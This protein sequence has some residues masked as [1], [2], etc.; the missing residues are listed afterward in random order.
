MM[1]F[2]W[3]GRAY[4]PTCGEEAPW[5][6]QR[7]IIEHAGSK[8]EVLV[9]VCLECGNEIGIPKRITSRNTHAKPVAAHS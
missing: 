9:P 5:D 3:N 4:C 2:G 1:K 6:Y 8:F 7:A